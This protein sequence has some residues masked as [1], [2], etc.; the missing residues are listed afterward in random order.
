MFYF[1]KTLVY[2]YYEV[3]REVEKKRKGE[4]PPF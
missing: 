2:S 1:V 4:P 3:I